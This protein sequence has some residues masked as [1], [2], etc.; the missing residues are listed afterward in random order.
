MDTHIYDV[1][2]IVKFRNSPVVQWVGLIA[3][4]AVGPGCNPC[5]GN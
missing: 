3:L 1:S 5:L 4:N 2:K